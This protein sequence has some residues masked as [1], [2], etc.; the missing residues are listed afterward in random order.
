MTEGNYLLES[1]LDTLLYSPDDDYIENYL[2]NWNNNTIHK[3]FITCDLSKEEVIIPVTIRSL[4]EVCIIKILQN[5]LP[6][7]DFNKIIAVP[8]IES[9]DSVS[10]RSVNSIIKNTELYHPILLQKYVTTKNDVYH[11]AFGCILNNNY[12]P[13]FL[14]TLVGNIVIGNNRKL[15]NYKEL[16]IFIHPEV[17]INPKDAL[18]KVILTKVLPYMLTIY[19]KHWIPTNRNY[20][21]GEGLKVKVVVEDKSDLFHTPVVTNNEEEL[22]ELLKSR[23]NDVTSYLDA[24]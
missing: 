8:L 14:A 23:V 6:P 17:I 13:M 3:R 19:L 2:N 20:L 15:F 9:H 4:V 12:Q 22:N 1:G 24:I 5:R 18:N 21:L 11:K 7:N 10:I 16:R